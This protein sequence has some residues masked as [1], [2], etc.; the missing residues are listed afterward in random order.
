[1]VQA[2]GRAA[3]LTQLGLLSEEDTEKQ[4]KQAMQA[5]LLCP[6][7]DQNIPVTGHVSINTCPSKYRPATSSYPQ[8]LW[9]RT[10]QHGHYVSPYSQL[11]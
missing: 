4:C 2:R 5:H 8:W 11:L 3:D 1:M 6:I 10:D 7:H 9:L